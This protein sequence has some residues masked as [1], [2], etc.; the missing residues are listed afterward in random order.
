MEEKLPEQ[1]GMAFH[2]YCKSCGMQSS[3][4]CSNSACQAAENSIV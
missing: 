1:E 2:Q 3:L 4:S